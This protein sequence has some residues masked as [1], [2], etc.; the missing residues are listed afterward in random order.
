MKDDV[1]KYIYGA[2]IVFV[3]GVL[4]WVSFI[5]MSACNGISLTCRQGTLPVDRTPVP[6][7]IPAT[8][9]VMN[10]GNGEV[11]VSN[12]DICRVAAVDLIGAWV[13]ANSPEKDVFQFVDV[14]G[15]NCEATFADVEPLFKEPNLW[16]SG[17]LACTSCHS[18]DVTISPAQLDLSSYAGILAGSRRAD[19]ESKGTDILGGGKWEK[20][21]LYEFLVTS[22]ADVPGHTEAASSSSFVFTGKPLPASNLTATPKP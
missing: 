22:K 14:N 21:L 12:P 3:V 2:L 15:K 16:N 4:I 20:S 1:R 17:S 8:L 9:P 19:V 10:K 5:Y 18:V 6:T 7:L 11:P 13:S